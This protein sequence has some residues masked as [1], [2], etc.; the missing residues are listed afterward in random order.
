MAYDPRFTDDRIGIFIPCSSGDVP[1]LERMLRD[2][3]SVEV[4]HAA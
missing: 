4:R 2:A 3:G 1:Q